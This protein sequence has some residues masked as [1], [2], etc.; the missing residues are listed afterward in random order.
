[1]GS[2]QSRLALWNSV[3]MVLIIILLGLLVWFLLRNVLVREFDHSLRVTSE[4]LSR[5][6]EHDGKVIVTEMAE[7]DFPRFSRTE[8]PDY[9]Q[10]FDVEGRSIER[11]MQLAENSLAFRHVFG[12]EECVF[13]DTVL[14]DGRPGRTAIVRFV[15]LPDLDPDP[16]QADGDEG[17]PL[18]AAWRIT[19]GSDPVTLIVARDRLDLD[20]TLLQ[21]ARLI[22]LAVLLTTVA[23]PLC[24]IGVSRLGLSPLHKTVSNIEKIDIGSLDSKF[25]AGGTPREVR[26][27]V[28]ALNRMLQRLQ[29]GYQRE[30]G[31]TGN[32]AHELR[33]PIAGLRS[34]LEVALSRNREPEE[35]R[36]SLQKCLQIT[37]QTEAVIINLLTLARIDSGNCNLTRELFALN[38]LVD[39]VWGLCEPDAIASGL[40]IHMEPG[41]LPPV[42]TDREK[43]RLV[44]RNLF[45]NAACHADVGTAI[46]VSSDRERDRVR[47]RISNRSSRLQPNQ[48]GKIFDRFWQQ[49]EVRSQTGRRSGIGLSLCKSIIE[50]LGGEIEAELDD[51]GVFS[52]CICLP[53]ES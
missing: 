22:G 39:E 19:D 35:Y 49:D 38:D 15:P 53:L 6:I 11:S 2:L 8:R 24:S 9:Y 14:P 37:H 25:D 36:K 40:T 18:P 16:E 48:V 4:T 5:L 30:T 34:T 12:K 20:S 3:C 47:V 46:R 33:T 28:T 7:M 42:R 21:F 13:E 44:L 45:E 10:V 1:M 32:V 23:V 26:S 29:E 51:R 43:V 17:L 50:L 31:F 52:I 27:L 41:E